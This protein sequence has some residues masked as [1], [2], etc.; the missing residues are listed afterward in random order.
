MFK[1]EGAKIVFFRFDWI[2][3]L[4]LT[5]A[6]KRNAGCTSEECSRYLIVDKV[7]VDNS[8]NYFTNSF[9]VSIVPSV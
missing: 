1:D 5:V 6:Y 4:Q 3:F 7:V 2:I 8:L 9:T